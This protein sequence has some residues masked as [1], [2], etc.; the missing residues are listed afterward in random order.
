MYLGLPSKTTV[1][2]LLTIGWLVVATHLLFPEF[3]DSHRTL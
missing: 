3:R 2:G 1:V